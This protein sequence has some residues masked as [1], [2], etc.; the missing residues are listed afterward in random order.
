[1]LLIGPQPDRATSSLLGR[2]ILTP[3][4]W[5][6]WCLV[7]YFLVV[8][9]LVIQNNGGTQG[10]E[11][12]WVWSCWLMLCLLLAGVWLLMP[13]T[14]VW[15]STS[16]L[17]WLCAGCIVLTLPLIWS[18]HRDWQ[19]HALPRLMGLWGGLFVYYSLL[20][21][22]ISS[23]QWALIWLCIVAGA[24]FQALFVI[25]EIFFPSLVPAL[26]QIAA[27]KFAYGVFQQKNVTASYLATGLALALGLL[28][29][30]STRWKRARLERWRLLFLGACLVA[31][32][33]VLLM[34]HSRIGW[35]GWGVDVVCVYALLFCLSVFSVSRRR[36]WLI[37]ML[38][39]IGVGIGYGLSFFEP[40][41]LK[42]PH[43]ASNAQRWL[44]VKA[45]WHMFI[46]SPIRG[47]GY[48]GFEYAFQHWVSK[49]RP[50]LDTHEVMNH[51]HNEILLWAVEGGI[52]SLI[53][54][55]I[56]GVTGI[57]LLFR[58]NSARRFLIG[59]SL[60]PILLHT[61]VEYPVYLSSAHW[62]I[63]LLLLASC[64]TQNNN[65]DDCVGIARHHSF[66]KVMSLQL[67]LLALSGALLC[68]VA[69]YNQIAL[70]KFETRTLPDDEIIT[71]LPMPWLI[72]ERYTRDMASLN[73]LRFQHSYDKQYLT[74]YIEISHRWLLTRVDA[75]LYENL[76]E[77]ERYLHLTEAEES[78]SREAR[79]LFPY[80]QR[81]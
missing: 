27:K 41:Q 70:T 67:V 25:G 19:Y 33:A 15:Q 18:P 51:P 75:D 63:L 58:H 22:R 68:I 35:I 10:D 30:N 2:G 38:P 28:I 76:T 60:L 20:Q 32:S 61:Q 9:N 80:D 45:C 1:M 59:M 43:D 66:H 79:S 55:V 49:Q 17:K 47:W 65:D 36:R 78:D 34:L 8:L 40:S 72:N 57:R 7:C 26:S 54:L 42:L 73:I 37:C 62:L 24:L 74:N 5:A 29:D 50:L 16:T 52:T 77:M 14:I 69:L 48:G 21:C 39:I 11:L 3:A 56:V 6:L 81:F 23:R 44:T 31:L 4:R 71:T 46:E 13:M 64:D 12:P 53:G